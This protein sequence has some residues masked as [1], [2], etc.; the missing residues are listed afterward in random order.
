M[1]IDFKH[2]QLAQFESVI[3]RLKGSPKQYLDFASVAD[4]Y[5]ANLDFLH[6]KN[7]WQ[8]VVDTA[9]QMGTAVT[10]LGPSLTNPLLIYTAAALMLTILVIV[11]AGILVNSTIVNPLNRLVALTKRIS[12]GETRVR[13]DI[14]AT[15]KSIRWQ[16]L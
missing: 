3:E 12:Q 8:Q 6:L 11:A 4:F 15:T 9:T 14:Q 16:H 1:L 2:A 7:H 13:A 5:Q 10:R